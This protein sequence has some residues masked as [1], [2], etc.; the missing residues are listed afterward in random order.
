MYLSYQN[1][2][3]EGIICQYVKDSSR[4][5]KVIWKRD[6]FYSTSYTVYMTYSSFENYN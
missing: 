6:Y 4:Y 2:V 5:H 1:E 3:I